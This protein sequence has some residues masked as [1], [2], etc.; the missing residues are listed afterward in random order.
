MKLLKR[1]SWVVLTSLRSG[2]RLLLKTLVASFQTFQVCKPLEN[3]G[4]ELGFHVEEGQLPLE[5]DEQ[6]LNFNN[7]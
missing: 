4:E 6:K 5:G 2:K 3:L 7:F 1:S